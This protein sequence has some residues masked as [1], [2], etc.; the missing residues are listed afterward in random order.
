M[1]LSQEQFNILKAT[2]IAD[3]TAGPIRAAGDTTALGV[4]CNGDS[5]ITVWRTITSG[6]VIRNAIVWAN[7]TPLDTPDGTATYTNRALYAQAKQISLQTLVQGVAQIATGVAGVRNG[8]Q[9]CLTKL[10]T[11]A[12]GSTIA[13]GWQ[14]GVRPAMQRLATRA[15]ALFAIGTG[16]PA[17]PSDLVFE[18]SVS[19]S[20]L[21]R[22]VN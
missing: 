5:A 14:S 1:T 17:N 10:P 20:E 15:E 4:W 12:G 3:P 22:L 21:N 16:T 13:A 6:D 19:I 18:G 11:G 7:M 2:I 9:D 8:L